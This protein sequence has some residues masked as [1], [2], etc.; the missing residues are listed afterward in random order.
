VNAEVLAALVGSV[1]GAALAGVLGYLQAWWSRDA[2][3]R[4]E[5]DR[6]RLALVREI[7]RYRLDQ[8]R[9]VGPLNELP[10]VFGDDEEVLRLY[11]QTLNAADANAR[12]LSLTDL[13][14]RLASLVGLPA[15]VQTSDVERGLAYAG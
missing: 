10:L 6:Q 3:A 9:L 15:K 5:R 13:V 4:L 12:S 1:V 8:E 14:N 7:M 11:R 2:S